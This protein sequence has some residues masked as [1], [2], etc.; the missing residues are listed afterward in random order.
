MTETTI[1]LAALDA[2][3]QKALDAALPKAL[4]PIWDAL[5]GLKEDFAGLKEDFAGMKKDV[6]VLKEDVAVLK[7][8]VAGLKKDVAGLK[9]DVSILS[10]AHSNSIARQANGLKAL[11]ADLVPLPSNS[12]GEPWGK[13]VAQPATFMVLAV[14]GSETVPGTEGARFLWNRA[15]SRAFIKEAVGGY[16]TDG[17]DSEGVDGPK[18][19]SARL[20][21]IDLMGGDHTRVMSSVY[22]LV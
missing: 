3:L 13:N 11:K 20:K 17:T 9:K 5:N 8:D 4:A 6:A 18:S 7:E 15:K 12:L 2:A 1:T 22:T 16:D 21:V 10:A 14:S 19:R